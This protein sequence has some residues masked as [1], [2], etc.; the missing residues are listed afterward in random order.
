MY[1]DC[2][3]SQPKIDIDEINLY[4][5]MNESIVGILKIRNTDPVSMY[6]AKLIQS[7]Q[8]R[9]NYIH[10]RNDEVFIPPE[11]SKNRGED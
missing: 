7:L 3:E 5:E 9:L 11:D 8:A 4:P 10:N 1:E 6:A 2:E